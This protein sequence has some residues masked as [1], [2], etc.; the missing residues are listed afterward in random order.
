MSRASDRLVWAVQTLGVQPH[1]RVLEAGCG[2]G[3]A[4]TLIAERLVDG[5][6]VGVDRSP[7]MTAAARARNA[8][9]VDAGRAVIVTAPLH[10]ADLG[11]ARFDKVLAVHSPP[12]LRGD[13][14]RDLAIIRRHLDE[15]GALHVVAQPL[16]TDPNAGAATAEALAARVEPHGFA[17]AGTLIEDVGSRPIVCVVARP[18]SPAA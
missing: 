3:V 9:H 8:A 5:I 11:D 14:R 13:P 15:D 4:I 17:V 2:H 12:L 16:G 10:E 6:V 1:D 7:T 18:R